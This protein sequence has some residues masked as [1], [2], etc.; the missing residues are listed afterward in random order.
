M[1]L[2]LGRGIER[3]GGLECPN[4]ARVESANGLQR[5]LEKRLN[6]LCSVLRDGQAAQANSL[7][8]LFQ[9]DIGWILGRIGHGVSSR[10]SG[11]RVGPASWCFRMLPAT[12]TGHKGLITATPHPALSPTGRGNGA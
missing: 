12:V 11:P 9:R 10:S 8:C 5:V 6:H 3:D 4:S 7:A 1:T 2:L